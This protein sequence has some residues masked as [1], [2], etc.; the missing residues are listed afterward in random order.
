[1]SN[2][3]FVTCITPTYGRFPLL[4]EMVWCWINQTYPN[5]ELIIVNDQKNLTITCDVPGVKVFNFN[6]RFVGLG[7][8]RNFAI[9]HAN[10]NSEF[11]CPWDDDDLFFPE[12]IEFLV[13][14]FGEDK[15]LERVKNLKHFVSIDNNFF[16]VSYDTN[17]TYFGASL[18]RKQ[19][20]IDYPFK[21]YLVMGEDADLFDNKKLNMKLEQNPLVSSFVHRRGMGIPHASAVRQFSYDKGLQDEIGKE[22]Y[23]K[24]NQLK[25]EVTIEIIPKLVAGKDIYEKIN[26]YRHEPGAADK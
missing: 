14:I 6:E 17:Q 23:M 1:M 10:P 16:N 15:A 7:A 26:R 2:L 13:G 22:F 4:C 12:H 25:E 9:A 24:T 5:K 21:D 11:I 8:K 3:P 19:V 18:F 20:F